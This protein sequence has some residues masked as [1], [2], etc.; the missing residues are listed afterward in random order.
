M[1]AQ[2][3]AGFEMTSAPAGPLEVGENIEA[4]E[5]KCATA[6][7]TKPTRLHTLRPKAVGRCALWEVICSV[8]APGPIQ[9]AC[10]GSD[11]RVAG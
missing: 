9:R 5:R 6:A 4:L 8:A 2:V 11:S 3:R 1:K 7:V 10:C